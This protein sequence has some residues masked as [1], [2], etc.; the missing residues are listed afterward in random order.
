MNIVI[1]ILFCF[2]TFSNLR[3]K[4]LVHDEYFVMIPIKLAVGFVCF[5]TIYI[6]IFGVLFKVKKTPNPNN[7]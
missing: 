4:I 5:T 6:W 1:F 2:N 3:Y 7:S